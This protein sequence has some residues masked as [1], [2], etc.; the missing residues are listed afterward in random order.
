MKLNEFKNKLNDM[1]GDKHIN[2][3]D[4]EDKKLYEYWLKNKP[5]HH[6]TDE[7]LTYDEF[8]TD[9]LETF[10]NLLVSKKEDNLVQQRNVLNNI[11]DIHS[12]ALLRKIK[13]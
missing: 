2:V 9:M 10:P 12:D 3:D 4:N 8:R 1:L 11:F 5:K 13:E 7:F 6:E